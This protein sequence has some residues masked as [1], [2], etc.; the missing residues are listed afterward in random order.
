MRTLEDIENDLR[1]AYSELK[2]VEEIYDEL[3]RKVDKIK[4]E[5]KKFIVENHLFHPMGDLLQYS[6]KELM[7]IELVKKNGTELET[8][9]FFNDKELLEIDSSGHFYYSS[10]ENGIVRFNEKTGL[11][12]HMYYG[13]RTP[14]EYIGYLELEEG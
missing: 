14:K 12:D 1:T 10:Y 6:G 4:K 2:P 3:K 11:Y 7:F 8:E 5:R 9:C 13:T